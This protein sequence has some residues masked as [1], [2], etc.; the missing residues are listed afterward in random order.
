MDF[1]EDEIMSEETTVLDEDND[2]YHEDQLCGS[3]P[4][5]IAFEQGVKMAQ[6]EEEEEEE[7][8]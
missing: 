1:Y 2:T 6:E 4:W 8:E 7:I 3:D 5:E